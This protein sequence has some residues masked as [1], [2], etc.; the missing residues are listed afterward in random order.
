V[1]YRRRPL[2][3]ELRVRARAGLGQLLPDERPRRDPLPAEAQ[4]DPL[5]SAALGQLVHE[6]EGELLRR[7]RGKQL[8]PVD[9]GV[10]RRQLLKAASAAALAWQGAPWLLRPRA[11]DAQTLPGDPLTV[12]TLEAFAD[13]L[14][15]GEK[16]SLLD[17]AI[18]GAV[19]GPGAVQAG[20]LDTLTF[21]AA[22]TGPLLPAFAAALNGR[23]TAYAATNVILLDPTVPPFVSLDFAQRSDLL[24]QLLDGTDPDQI[25]WFA[26]A[27]LVF[28]AYHTAAHLHLADATR[29]GH[30]GLAALRFPA[31]DADDLYRHPVF[32]YGR[33]LARRHPRT[34]RGGPA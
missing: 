1:P 20:A 29:N 11:V 6:P 22:G 13:T 32:S 9:L 28:I 15:P 16:R 7:M 17:R 31:P 25:V 24:V 19:S 4:R 2:L 27:G 14:I 8:R 5:P 26:L 21:P 3:L 12:A 18:A 34:R 10:T 30:P 33:M 23:A